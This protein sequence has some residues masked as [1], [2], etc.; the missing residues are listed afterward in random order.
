MNSSSQRSDPY[1]PKRPPC[2][3]RQNNNVKEV[4]TPPV[5]SKLCTP[6]IAV[7]TAVRNN[8]VKTVSEKQLLKQRDARDDGV[9]DLWSDSD[10]GHCRCSHSN[11]VDIHGCVML[12]VLVHFR[13]RCSELLIRG[14]LRGCAA[15]TL[16]SLV[17]FRPSG[18][19]V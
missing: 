4:G 1:R 14:E 5:R 8:V 16:V 15:C 12:R 2:S 17:D 9:S 7:S 11:T 3:H 10:R 13:T 18:M 19:S 6:L